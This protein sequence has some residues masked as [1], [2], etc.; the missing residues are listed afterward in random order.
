MHKSINHTSINQSFNKSNNQSINDH[1]ILIKCTGVT[2]WN[3]ERAIKISYDGELFLAD[4]I[5]YFQEVFIV[6]KRFLPIHSSFKHSKWI[7]TRI[8][9]RT[10]KLQLT[11]ASLD[12]FRSKDRG[13]VMQ[14]VVRT[15][16]KFLLLITEPRGTAREETKAKCTIL[17]A[18]DK[19]TDLKHEVREMRNQ[20]HY[21]IIQSIYW[22]GNK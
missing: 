18:C 3:Y 11:L 14:I 13:R 9:C 7:L 4:A 15:T 2:Y 16:M 19:N 21:F 22:K 20:V 12:I 8:L 1:F 10:W 5:F 6:I 17:R